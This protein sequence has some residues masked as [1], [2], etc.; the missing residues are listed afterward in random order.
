LNYI[1]SKRALL[2]FID[3]AVGHCEIEKDNVT[4]CDLFSGTGHVA[5]H[6]KKRGYRI[7]ANDLEDFSYSLINHYIGNHNE[8]KISEYLD[9]FNQLSGI[10][11]GF[12]FNNYCPSGKYS[13][14]EKKDGTIMQR[15]Y[16]TDQNGKIIDEARDLIDSW[17]VSN[18]IDENTYAYLLAVILESADKI[19]NTTSVYGAFLKEYK[20]GADKK[21]KFSFI[22]NIITE[23]EHLVFKEDSNDLIKKIEGDILYL[24]PPYNNR[25]YGANYHVLN[26]ISKKDNPEVRGITGMRDSNTS[27]WCKK[28]EVEKIFEDLIENA[29]FKYILLSYNNEGL[30]SHETIK[31][32]MEKHGEY[33]V[34]EK[35]YSRYKADKEHEKRKYKAK[36]VIE[37]IHILKI[38]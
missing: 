37:Y 16:F 36:S 34:I 10:D 13:S 35:D 14:V 28:N 9:R 15:K 23:Q 26:T 8:I 18:E 7:I 27:L 33:S 29:N 31:N 4:F 5:K 38:T 25:Q 17:L 30:M 3:L 20:K 22:E 21:I 19:A 1:G 6:Y 11:T 12:V 2:D 24:D 32:I